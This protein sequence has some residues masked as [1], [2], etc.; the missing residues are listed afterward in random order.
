ML[1]CRGWLEREALAPGGA[2]LD[3]EAVAWE[4][5]AADDVAD[6][7]G[8]VPERREAPG[9]GVEIGEVEAPAIFLAAAM[10]A[11][12]PIEPTLETAGQREIFAVD[13]QNERV[14]EYPGVEPVRQDNLDPE[15]PAA[16]VGLLLPF[17]DPGE[18]VATTFGDLADR[19]RD[20]G[21][22]KPVEARLEPLI[23]AR[24]D[25]RPTKV[26]IS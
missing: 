26:R 13:G 11:D 21:R 3:R 18:T 16:G 14:V 2:A 7:V 17:V 24:A 6:V 23:V 19:G 1:V 8:E 4:R 5:L 20:G 9:L 12:D 22:L 15:R 25:P 10:L